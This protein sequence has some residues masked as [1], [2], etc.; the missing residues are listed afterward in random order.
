MTY[1]INIFNTNGQIQIDDSSKTMEFISSYTVPFSLGSNP[2]S[3]PYGGGATL[4][5]PY[6]Q[7]NLFNTLVFVTPNIGDE[8]SVQGFIV[9]A[10][11][12][13]MTCSIGGKPVASNSYV[14]FHVY[15]RISSEASGIG[16]NVYNALGEPVFSSES[17]PPK[18]YHVGITSFTQYTPVGIVYSVDTSAYTAKRMVS[19]NALNLPSIAAEYQGF[20]KAVYTRFEVNS[21]DYVARIR[22]LKTVG[23][24]GYGY[25]R[26]IIGVHY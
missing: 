9:D 21:I 17:K 7:F 25:F 13:T 6:N 3:D 8:I 16:I 19:M 10:T 12:N 5:L 2:S 18:L 11:A 20:T 14:T 26:Q 15:R 23:T 24:N 1:G 22:Q 4:S